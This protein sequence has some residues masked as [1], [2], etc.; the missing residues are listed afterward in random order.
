MAQRLLLVAL[1]ALSCQVAK[2]SVA[3]RAADVTASVAARD[4]FRLYRT[5]CKSWRPGG[6]L[7]DLC[8]SH[9]KH[10]AGWARVWCG[11]RT[12][13]WVLYA[14]DLRMRDANPDACFAP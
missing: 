14:D 10:W 2:R 11:K 5:T 1:I 6:T 12:C 8:Y 3:E 9:P 4:G 7:C 13:E